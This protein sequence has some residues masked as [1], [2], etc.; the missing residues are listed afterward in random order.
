MARRQNERA[1]GHIKWFNDQKGSGFIT[2]TDEGK[3]LFVHH[4]GIKAGSG[5]FRSLGEYEIIKFEV[6][7]GGDGRTK[8]ID[9]TDPDEGPVQ[10][11]N[12]Q[13]T[14]EKKLGRIEGELLEKNRGGYG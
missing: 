11:G 4:S 13:R 1:K 7:Q 8:A 10:G 6:E 14:E 12:E 3:Y 2:P 9:I 5:G